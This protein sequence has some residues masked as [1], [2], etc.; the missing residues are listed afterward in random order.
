MKTITTNREDWTGRMGTVKIDSLGS[1][2]VQDI[3]KFKME[4]KSFSDCPDDLYPVVTGMGGRWV[5]CSDGGC[6]YFSAMGVERSADSPYVAFA[7]VAWNI[8]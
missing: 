8:F 5:G 6:H 3:G 2:V 4:H 7:K 1:F